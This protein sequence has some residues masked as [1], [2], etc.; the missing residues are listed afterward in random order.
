MINHD[1]H[2]RKEDPLN[3]ANK[4]RLMFVDEETGIICLL[5]DGVIYLKHPVVEQE[6]AVDA[7]N[8]WDSPGLRNRMPW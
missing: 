3:K 4:K 2:S 8:K 5:I 7:A 1:K 6:N